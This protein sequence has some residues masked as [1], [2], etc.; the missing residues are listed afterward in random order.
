MVSGLGVA[1]RVITAPNSAFA[2]M[3]DNDGRYFA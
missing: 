3:R 2:R 1:P